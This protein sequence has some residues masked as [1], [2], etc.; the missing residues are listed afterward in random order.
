MVPND[1]KKLKSMLK[2]V[3]EP[4]WI[5][6][7]HRPQMAQNGEKKNS[8]TYKKTCFYIASSSFLKGFWATWKLAKKISLKYLIWFGMLLIK[9]IYWGGLLNFDIIN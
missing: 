6:F 9:Y 7:N 3:F 2:H 1:S 5:G 4:F 8:K